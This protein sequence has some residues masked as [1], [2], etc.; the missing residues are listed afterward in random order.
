MRKV[1]TLAG[2]VFITSVYQGGWGATWYVNGSAPEFG[3]GSSPE[4]PLET[5]QEGIDGASDGD[6]V[7][8]AEGTYVEN[9]QFKGK[10]I[11]LRSTDP[12]DPTVVENTTIDGGDAGPVVTFAGTEDETCTLSGFT[13]R[14]GN[15]EIGAG[16]CGGTWES[17][18]HA[19]IENNVITV[20]L[21]EC[22]GGLAYC[23]GL[24]RNNTIADNHASA[25]G[26]G[27]MWCDG[28][29]EKNDIARNSA[30][31]GGGLSTCGGTIQ[32]NTVSY[33]EALGAFPEGFGGGLYRCDGII[34]NN[35]ISR[36]YAGRYGG[37]LV[38]SHGTIRN[39]TIVA[40]SSS[41]AGGVGFCTAVI[42]N[43]IFWGNT[44]PSGFPQAYFSRIPLHSCIQD[45]TG[46]GDG[47]TNQNPQFV[48]FGGGNY[49]LSENSPCIGSGANQDWMWDAADPDG[50]PRIIGAKVDMGAYE[51]NTLTDT[52]PPYVSGRD[53]APGATRVLLGAN[54]VLHVK[55]HGSGVD[56]T[57]ILIRVKG[58]GVTP[59]IT[60]TPADYTVSYDPPSDFSYSEEV[61]VTV[62]AADLTS[63]ANVMQRLTYSFTTISE[64]SPV[65]MW[66]V[67][68]SVSTSGDG[69]SWETAFKTI[70]D[71]IDAAND[72][73]TV[74]VAR[75][76]YVE[77]VMFEGKNI[78][79][80]SSNPLDPNVVAR[81]VIDGNQAGPV[82]TFAGTEGEMC[83]LSG[84]TIR[85]GKADDGGG[86]CGGTWG[87]R[88]HATIENNVITANK[89]ANRG[90]GVAFC[91]G[92]I[93]YSTISGNSA[94]GMCPQSGGNECGL[95]GGIAFCDGVIENNAIT[96]NY[97][98]FWGG[99]IAVCAGIIQNNEVLQNT[100]PWGTGPYVGPAI[101]GCH[102]MIR[103]NLIPRNSGNDPAV[104]GCEG[105]MWNNTVAA[106]SSLYGGALAWCHGDI[107][108]VIVWGNTSG[109]PTAT[110]IYVSSQPSYSCIQSGPLGPGSISTDP[111]FL[112]AGAGN[113]HLSE[114]S[115]CIDKGENEDW[116][117]DAKALN[118]SPRIIDFDNDGRARVDMGAYEAREYVPPVLTLNGDLSII[119][120]CGAPY[121]EPGYSATDNYDGD[122]TD[123]VVVT[124]WG[125][126]TSPGTQA[127]KYN[128]KD[129]SGNPAPEKVRI[130][131]VR[132]TTP[133]VI[134]LL[135]DNPMTIQVGTPYVE[136][137]YTATDTCDGDV[138]ALVVVSG[139]VDSN[140]VG[141]YI[142]RYNGIDWSVNPAQVTRTVNVVEGP[143]FRVVEI[144]QPTPGGGIRL[145]WNSCPGV[146]Y[147]V[148]SCSDLVNGPWTEEAT[149]LADAESATW[150]DPTPA[151]PIKF[152]DV[153]LK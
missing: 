33:N 39:N 68:G 146:T 41:W 140:A 111:K 125:D 1:L 52:S 90:G 122:I 35:V 87:N 12:S 62:N 3:D 76:T 5:I 65:A 131:E 113:Y 34:Q 116:M 137:G 19:T 130:V 139:S 80:R 128:V 107:R 120:E 145:T 135:G 138:T 47:N 72:G 8:V 147:T 61:F 58:L 84:F 102:A 53:P 110:H 17:R 134:T 67:D 51:Y 123:R 83:M 105:P 151:G 101:V 23:D 152:Y 49:R 95:G 89:A 96:G 119:L 7:I 86:V 54:I 114:G 94:T 57:R 118:G 91:D 85:N 18:T 30:K 44:A 115:P 15:A 88:T 106:N 13:I 92:L 79:L 56:E 36:N 97:S 29:I 99:G 127:L 59:T 148:W 69:T 14:N 31:W 70:Q 24:I 93:R 60:G 27:L 104:A 153:E 50:N 77:N 150:T 75:G 22:G 109:D 108:N 6:T 126:P 143:P 132:D 117:V 98:A 28:I 73:D 124:G 46:G 112:D 142:L 32:N 149:V 136:P 133:P 121:I 26:G 2:I 10:N 21:A 40:N 81:T 63:P 103:N 16:I 66:Y 38:S 100:T 37:G 9:V 71:G 74:V 64:S 55:D 11:V 43:C 25:S 82:V 48:D 78:T 4:K 45:W 42:Q 144:V 129:S 20:N 141:T